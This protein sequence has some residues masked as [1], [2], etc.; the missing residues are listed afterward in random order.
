MKQEKMCSNIKKKK[1][2]IVRETGIELL[3][4][5]NVI[6][7]QRFANTQTVEYDYKLTLYFQYKIV[8]F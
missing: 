3:L 7:I 2:N 1:Q 8:K 4:G 6:Y 5:N